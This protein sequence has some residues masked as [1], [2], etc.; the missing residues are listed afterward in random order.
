LN[1]ESEFERGFLGATLVVAAG[2]PGWNQWLGFD[3]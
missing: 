2:D 3:M 1:C